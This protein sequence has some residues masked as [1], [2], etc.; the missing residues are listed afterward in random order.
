MMIVVRKWVG[1][2]VSVRGKRLLGLVVG[3]CACMMSADA[4]VG[5]FSVLE[6]IRALADFVQDAYFVDERQVGILLGE[7]LERVQAV[8]DLAPMLQLAQ[9][10][11]TAVAEEA[12]E[13]RVAVMRRLVMVARRCMCY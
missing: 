9:A 13:E 3:F 11:E 1:V 12:L 10:L 2:R 7:L 5:V 6:R 4:V 8:G